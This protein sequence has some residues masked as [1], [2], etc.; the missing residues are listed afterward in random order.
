MKASAAGAAH[1]WSL[2]V[3]MFVLLGSFPAQDEWQLCQLHLS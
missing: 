1:S 2:V 3:V